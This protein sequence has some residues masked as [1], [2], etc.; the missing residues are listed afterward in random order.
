MNEISTAIQ[1]NEGSTEAEGAVLLR[2][3]GMSTYFSA[4]QRTTVY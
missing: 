4:A 1:S 3:L 2:I